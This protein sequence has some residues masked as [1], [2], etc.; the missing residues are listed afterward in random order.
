VILRAHHDDFAPTFLRGRRGQHLRLNA[1][2]LASTS[3]T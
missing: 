2:N 1:Q 3:T